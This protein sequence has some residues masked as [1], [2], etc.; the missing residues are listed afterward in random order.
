MIIYLLERLFPYWLVHLVAIPTALISLFKKYPDPALHQIMRLRLLATLYLAWCL[1]VVLLQH[2]YDYIHLPPLLLGIAFLTLW[3]HCIDHISLFHKLLGY[4]FVSLAL[5]WSPVTKPA[6]LC[7]WADC[8]KQ[9]SSTEIRNKLARI[10]Y[11]DWQD[12]ERV[13]EFLKQ[14]QV[15]DYEV[16]CYSNDLVHLYRDLKLEPSTRY[17]YLN[18]HAIYFPS[19]RPLIKQALQKSPQRFVLTNL[20]AAG[21][22]VNQ[23]K[24]SGRTGIN[25]YPPHFPEAVANTVPLESADCVSFRFSGRA[26]CAR[27]SSRKE[28]SHKS[29]IE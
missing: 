20:M 29:L 11:P 18:T 17:V 27:E 19:K 5:N 4:G 8:L 23:A 24:E 9:G 26:S 10:P 21:L 22:L 7:L 25:S 6:H 13:G 28:V 14:Q 12:L 16:T 3:Y 1:Q 15:G 2:P